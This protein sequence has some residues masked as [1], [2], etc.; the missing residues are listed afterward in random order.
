MR[1]EGRIKRIN[2]AIVRMRGLITLI[3]VLITLL[4]LFSLLSSGFNKDALLTER[5]ETEMTESPGRREAEGSAGWK[6][7]G[8]SEIPSSLRRGIKAASFPYEYIVLFTSGELFTPEVLTLISSVK[9]KIAT[10]DFIGP[11]L[12]PFDIVTAEKSGSRIR[13]LKMSPVR[14]AGAWTEE[15]ASDFKARLESDTIAE[16]F[17]YAMTGPSLAIYARTA[18]LS[19]A[20]VKVLTSIVSPLREYGRVAISGSSVI[21]A[22]MSARIIR[23]SV[24]VFISSLLIASGILAIMYRS[25]SMAAASVLYAFITLIWTAE[26]SHLLGFKMTLISSLLPA[27][28]MIFSLIILTERNIKKRA[29]ITALSLMCILSSL[30]IRSAELREFFFSLALSLIY[31][32]LL[33]FFFIPAFLKSVSLLPGLCLKAGLNGKRHSYLLMLLSSLIIAAGLF[34]LMRVGFSGFSLK[35]F[36][37]SDEVIEDSEYTAR[38][39]GRDSLAALL[40]APDES[41]S[42]FLDLENIMKVYAYEDALS[43][44]GNGEV[45]II[46][47]SQCASFLNSVFYERD[48]INEESRGIVNLLFRIMSMRLDRAG[49]SYMTLINNDASELVLFIKEYDSSD[50]SAKELGKILFENMH[51]LPEGVEV[52]ILKDSSDT[53]GMHRGVYTSLLLLLSL[54]VLSSAVILREVR[55]AVKAALAV[56]L[57]VLAGAIALSITGLDDVGLTAFYVLSAICLPASLI[58]LKAESKEEREKGLSRAMEIVIITALLSLSLFFSDYKSIA[59][60]PVIIIISLIAFAFISL[61]ILSSKKDQ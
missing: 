8:D 3:I 33:S 34:S 6:A 48:G 12:S 47:F 24:A 5:R 52:R 2:E 59:H 31:A 57:A 4:F 25:A 16:G 10:L 26:S 15:S 20:E 17:L 44:S 29:L 21:K 45:K 46:S 49:S 53:S 9:E 22:Y 1:E 32:F 36:S 37:K 51:F 19:A 42:F 28:I 54:I 35:N 43:S 50:D 39:V 30:L 60:Y 56:S 58:V 11:V 61:S 18:E 27:L 55:R 40:R 23:L 14:K 41:E 38:V 7:E 13:F